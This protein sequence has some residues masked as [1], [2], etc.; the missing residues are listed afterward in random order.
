[1]SYLQNSS[2]DW[3]P[4]ANYKAEQE[5]FRH[6]LKPDSPIRILWF[7][8]ETGVGKSRLVDEIRTRALV[9]Y[10]TGKGNASKP[11]MAVAL[12]PYRAGGQGLYICSAATPPGAGI[13]GMGGYNAARSVLRGLGR[14]PS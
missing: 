11:E 4:I 1:M 12:D 13:H 2:P 3:L 7:Y 6:F 5:Q 14:Q 10:A 9:D 8:G